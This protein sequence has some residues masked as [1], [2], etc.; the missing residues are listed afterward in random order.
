MMDT[1][2]ISLIG[3]TP[4]VRVSRLSKSV[5]AE[6]YVKLEYLNPTGSHKDRIAYYMIKD[7]ER[8]GLIKPG[9]IAVSYKHLTLPTN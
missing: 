2:I 4:I 1:S 8:R 6:I 7:A 3:N 9:D 5:G